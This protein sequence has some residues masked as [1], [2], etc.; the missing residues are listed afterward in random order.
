MIIRKLYRFE[1]A[2]IVRNC[3]TE[4][5]SKSIHGHSYIAEIFLESKKLDD[6][7]MVLDFSLLKPY[8]SEFVDSFDHTMMLWSGDNPIF[9]DAIKKYSDRY[10]VMSRNPT[11]ENIA[12][13]ILTASHNI[14]KNTTFYNG[15]SKNL[16][17]IK[18]IVHETATGYA[19]AT[20]KDMY[21][22]YLEFSPGVVKDW[23]CDLVSRLRG[24]EC[25][26]PNLLPI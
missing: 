21:P 12:A 15:E 24:E 17:V 23:S 5:C 8:V 2:H 3:T 4:R 26:E 18:T 22:L 7:G 10:I 19:E 1:A 9:L 20:I 14:I 25:Q 11:A 16:K 13:T 6:G